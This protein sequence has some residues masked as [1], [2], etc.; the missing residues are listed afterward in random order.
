MI[1]VT[2]KAFNSVIA[3]VAVF[4]IAASWRMSCVAQPLAQ[5]RATARVEPTEQLI[6]EG[7]AAFEQGDDMAAQTLFQKAL[8][9]N[10]QDVTAHTYRGI[11]A[12][13]A[14]ELAAAERHFAAAAT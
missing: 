5:T 3:I 8:A 1:V 7:V 9:A 12:D 4:T 2:L 14:G 6:N 11:I 10:P 13:R